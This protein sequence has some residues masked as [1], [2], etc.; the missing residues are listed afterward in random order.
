MEAE[1]KVLFFPRISASLF[2]IIIL[3]ITLLMLNIISLY[4]T[5]NSQIE[6][7]D[8]FD[9][10]FESL[11]AD[12]TVY[13]WDEN[14]ESSQVQI[15]YKENPTNKD[16]ILL[17]ISKSSKSGHS[18]VGIEFKEGLA[19]KKNDIIRLHLNVL[20]NKTIFNLI[21]EESGLFRDI[22]EEWIK[23][24]FLEQTGN[25]FI[26][27]SLESFQINENHQPTG[28]TD[29]RI[30]DPDH[31]SQIVFLLS[32]DKPYHYQI[33]SISVVRSGFNVVT[34]AMILIVTLWML[35]LTFFIITN[36]NCLYQASLYGEYFKF[37]LY[38]FVIVFI[39]LY[40][41][42]LNI[43]YIPLIVFALIESYSSF[44][45][46]PSRFMRL[47]KYVS[48]IF[49][50]SFFFLL[51]EKQSWYPILVFAHCFPLLVINRI[52]TFLL[53]IIYTISFGIVTISIP[54]WN[55]S[56]I[57]IGIG[58]G[59]LVVVWF[60]IY[61][62]QKF[63]I[64]FQKRADLEHE[65]DRL[66]HYYRSA[67]EN[68]SDIF[69]LIN[70]CPCTED[71]C[72]CD[73]NPSGV[74]LFNG[75]RDSLLNQPL[76]FFFHQPER[77]HIEIE[78]VSLDSKPRYIQN[79]EV[80]IKNTNYV[81]DIMLYQIDDAIALFLRDITKQR[82]LE[83]K[84]KTLER[85]KFIGNMA[86]GVAH[87]LN[88]IL[89]GILGNLS[90]INSI[91]DEQSRESLDNA[92]QAANLGAKLVQDL[93]HYSRKSITR[94]ISISLKPILDELYQILQN[95]SDPFIEFSLE[96]SHDL[97]SV[98]GDSVQI[99]SVLLNLGLNA[100][101]AV[102]TLRE[103]MRPPEIREQS[104]PITIRAFNRHIEKNEI[105]KYPRGYPGTF[106]CIEVTDTGI[107]IAE[108]SKK[109]IFEPFYTTKFSVGA[110]LGL[111]GA[112][113]IVQQHNG[114]IDFSSEY[115]KG[116]TFTVYIPAHCEDISTSKKHLK[117][118]P[119]LIGHEQILMIE[120]DEVNRLLGKQILENYGYTVI[121]AENG[122]KGFD[123]LIASG[124]MFDLIILDH[125]MPEM[126]GIEFIQQIRKREID[127]KVI[128]CSAHVT[129]NVQM[130]YKQ[131]KVDEII[132]KPYDPA[133]L[134]QIIR[135][136]LDSR[137]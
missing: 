83:N 81:F 110:G 3:A 10:T 48:S 99:H 8:L 118:Q 55:Q 115:K 16:K 134:I 21:V 65:R 119:H 130:Q 106:V 41:Q 42:K 66:L 30:L 60:F 38:Q 36:L 28:K 93:L 75:S 104:F 137:T 52:N 53:G 19:L 47:L 12:K 6:D 76:S 113:G 100:R 71:F 107:G 80:T 56:W 40:P 126:M 102:M 44:R 101:D 78:H 20:Q 127:T 31:I 64:Y 45:Y 121:E 46:P 27:V 116:S 111:A 11:R 114:W 96:V 18:G 98:L 103:T 120:D 136:V 4:Q 128:V 70:R 117:E 91:Q 124:D 131:Y 87:N 37:L 32:P 13:T 112:Y 63:A 122:Q 94:K 132:H 1:N 133:K 84:L 22:P 108:E 67:I 2:L 79:Y 49:V 85:I 5:W 54:V 59:L 92:K 7:F 15:Q 34:F 62:Q 26:D 88:N 25:Q 73:I 129:L 135:N 90:L 86:G 68:S 29:N 69:L 35:V 125:S 39:Q 109:R 123:R 24:I 95:E 57:W 43:Y 51:P 58:L 72:C 77:I 23:T 17:E 97:S 82:Q 74:K 50:F 89:A 61:L 33:H 14:S 105:E 9:P